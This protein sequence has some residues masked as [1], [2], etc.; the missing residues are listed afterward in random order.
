MF[1]CSVKLFDKNPMFTNCIKLFKT[2]IQKFVFTN[3]LW[4]KN[5]NMLTSIQ[6]Y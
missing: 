2:L 1:K 3:Q 5:K 6:N 4:L